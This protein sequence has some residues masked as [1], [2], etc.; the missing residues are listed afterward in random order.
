MNSRLM[1]NEGRLDIDWEQFFF[2][3]FRH[4]SY[5]LQENLHQ[6]IDQPEDCN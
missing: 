1:M 3:I 5:K 6:E 2:K 4:V